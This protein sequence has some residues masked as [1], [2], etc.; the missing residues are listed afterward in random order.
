MEYLIELPDN[1]FKLYWLDYLTVYDIVDIVYD[2]TNISD[3]GIRSLAGHCRNL[4]SLSVNRSKRLTDVGIVY[5]STLS[6]KLK[7]IHPERCED[8]V[9]WDLFGCRNLT[10]VSVASITKHCPLT[11]LC[12]NLNYC[13]SLTDASIVAITEHCSHLTFLSLL[14]CTHVSTQYHGLY[15][16]TN[17]F[18]DAVTHPLRPSLISMIES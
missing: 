2:R 16:S 9:V 11:I 1:L 6:T 3:I 12:L 10:D 14:F 8:L 17:V 15:R 5:L 18:R 4:T 13:T 7:E